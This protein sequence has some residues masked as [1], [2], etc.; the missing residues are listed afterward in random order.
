[1]PATADVTIIT[2]SMPSR[3]EMLGELCASVRAQTVAPANHLIAVDWRVDGFV[4]T[5]NRLASLVDTRWLMVMCDDDLLDPWHLATITAAAGWHDIAYTWCRSTG[6][7][8]WTPNAEF[9]AD[10]L[11]HTNFIPGGAALIRSDLWRDL[12]GYRKT[13]DWNQAEDWDFWIRALEHGAEFVCEPKI[14][15]T[16]RFHGQNLSLGELPYDCK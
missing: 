10:T 1:M 15:W 3:I 5:I 16:Y 8:G 14:T 6:R 13:A 4:A 2:A 11:R 7:D 9:D 12:G